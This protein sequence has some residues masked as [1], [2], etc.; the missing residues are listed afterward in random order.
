M[1]M[2]AIA[3]TDLHFNFLK[4]VIFRIDFQGVFEP[5]MEK[6]LTL[7]KPLVKSKGF[8][9][10]LRKKNNEIQ[11]NVGDLETP[12]SPLSKL[13]K[14]QEIH[15][16][17]NEDRGY[18]LDLSS[19]FVCLNINSTAYTPFE[20]YCAIISEIANIY[21][22]NIDF[23]SVNRVGIRKIN[24]CMLEKK[25]RI[26]E[27]FSSDYFG[28]F[29][30]IQNTNTVSSNRKDIFVIDVYK[31]NLSCNIEQGLAENRTLY[32]VSLDADIYV[33]D[34]SVIEKGI[35]FGVMNDILFDVYVSSLT[36][37][38]RAALSGDDETLFE[39]IIGVE[40]NE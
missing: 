33:D 14:S 29:N 11:I 25:E 23:I 21:K 20:D 36:E 16:F 32:K 4:S 19:S 34:V 18:V 12:E 22:E 31:V 30:A 35:N 8:S 9:R 37:K 27:F 7:V 38:F 17:I 24:V 28:Y 10:Y 26:N 3:R 13:V 2:G 39:G 15:S 5:E 40:R 6:I 1:S